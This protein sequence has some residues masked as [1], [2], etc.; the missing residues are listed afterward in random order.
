MLYMSPISIL[1]DVFLEKKIGKCIKDPKSHE[2]TMHYGKGS[3]K[4]NGKEK[5]NEEEG[6]SKPFND[7]LGPKDSSYLKK[8]KKKGKHFTYFNKLNHEESTCMKKKTD[9]MSHALQQNNLGNFIP[10]GVKKHK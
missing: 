4:Q 3:S 1:A 6:Y 8:K 10:E 5:H 7:S 2:I 9:L